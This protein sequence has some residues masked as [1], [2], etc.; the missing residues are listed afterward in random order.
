VAFGLPVALT[1]L[2]SVALAAATAALIIF[3][4]YPRRVDMEGADTPSAGLIIIS[5]P[6]S[7]WIE[8]SCCVECRV[9]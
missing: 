3:G 7:G 9:G 8:V 4:S 2:A 1:T 6:T 5:A